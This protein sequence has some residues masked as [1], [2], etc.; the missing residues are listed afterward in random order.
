[1][2]KPRLSVVYAARQW[3]KG[4]M[5]HYSARASARSGYTAT[6]PVSQ[7]TNMK[8]LAPAK[9]RPFLSFTCCRTQ[10]QQ[11]ITELRDEVEALKFE[12]SQL[13]AQL[14]PPQPQ[15]LSNEVVEHYPPP[16]TERE[17]TPENGSWQPVGK[18]RHPCKQQGS[19]QG[20]T[21]SLKLN[22]LSM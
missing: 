3:K 15:I 9:S 10:H 11:Q 5:K 6:V 1:M 19:K 22:P 16:S 14:Q 18:K 8:N 17:A 2:R 20:G 21:E 4:K 13:K 12:L 7:W